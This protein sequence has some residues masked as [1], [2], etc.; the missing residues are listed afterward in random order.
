MVCPPY[1]PEPLVEDWLARHRNPTSFLLHAIG[2]P[3]TIL[4]TMLVPAYL[5]LWSLDI[6]LLA[7]GLFVGGYAVQFLGHALEGSEPG[8]ITG[9]KNRWKQWSRRGRAA[10]K[11]ADVSRSL[12]PGT[13]AAGL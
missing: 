3:S 12:P 13:P 2:V 4:G 9:L 10:T 6:F 1:P 7:L 5:A 11:A 8:E